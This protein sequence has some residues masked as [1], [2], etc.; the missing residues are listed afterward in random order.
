[1]VFFKNITLLVTK[2]SPSYYQEFKGRESKILLVI[3]YYMLEGIPSVRNR[4]PE[5][6]LYFPGNILNTEEEL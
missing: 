4:T 2:F 3:F 6:N 1:M 5:S